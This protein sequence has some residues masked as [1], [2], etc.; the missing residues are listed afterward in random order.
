MQA[1]FGSTV[2]VH[3][4]GTLTDGTVFDSSHTRGEPLNFEVGSGY[5]I[6][7]FNNAVNGMNV[8]EVKSI[9]LT[10]EEAYGDYHPEALQTVPRGAFA[11]DFEFILGGTIQGNGPEGPFLAKIQ[12][13]KDETVTLDLNH[14]L[15]GKELNFEIEL[16]S[17]TGDTAETL[18]WNKSMKKAELVDVAVR[19]GLKLPEKVTKAQIIETLEAL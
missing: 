4:K 14:P 13:V 9:H 1:K 16:L 8:G 3:Y 11:P 15:A 18:T 5:M 17:V 10:P 7:G 2:D 12:E 19:S 6:S